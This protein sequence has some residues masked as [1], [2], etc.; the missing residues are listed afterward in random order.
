LDGVYKLASVNGIPKLKISENIEKTTFPGRKK[1]IRYI[2]GED[3]FYGDGILLASEDKVGTLFHPYYTIKHSDV[4]SFETEEILHPVM[5]DGKNI[6]EMPTPFESA[7]YA[8]KRLTRV[9]SE[10]KRFEN[11]HIY[12]V[13]ISRKLKDLRDEIAHN[14]KH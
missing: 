13:G 3:K 2:N 5:K 4:S 10:H 1:I 11:P 6:C 14:M 8:K 9:H 12:K 7:A